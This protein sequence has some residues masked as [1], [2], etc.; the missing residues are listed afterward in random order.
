MSE[1]TTL[2]DLL[3]SLTSVSSKASV[4][5]VDSAG[6]LH[7]IGTEIIAALAF[8]YAADNNSMNLDAPTARGLFRVDPNTTITRPTKGTGWDYGQVLNLATTSGLQIWFNYSGYIA[9]RSKG[10]STG[11]WSIWFV[12]DH[13]ALT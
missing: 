7:K 5:G 10:S 12:F 11:P 6:A 2:A 9:M 13:M 8:G 1:M 3:K 4:L